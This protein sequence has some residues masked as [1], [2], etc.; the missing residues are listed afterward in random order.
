RP[1]GGVENE[2]NPA[3]CDGI[4][5]V[6][7]AFQY[8]IDSAGGQTL[9]GQVALGPG[10]GDDPEAERDQKGN[11]LEHPR[12]VGV[13]D[14]GR[15][16]GGGRPPIWLLAKAMAKLRS[17]PITSPVDFISGPSTVS[18]PGKRANGKTASLTPMWSNGAALRPKLASVS[19]A[20]IR[21]AI[22]ATGTP[23]T[24]AT[25][26]TVREARGLTSST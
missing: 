19:P 26:G 5:D 23:I 11:G 15:H 10:G 16:G 8:L 22:L 2:L 25:K 1:L 18:T 17:M 12:L 20:M 6:G 21:A 13:P 4:D 3:I 14:R 9:L 7:A 24:L